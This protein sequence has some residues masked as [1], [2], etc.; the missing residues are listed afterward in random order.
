MP[1]AVFFDRDGVLNEAVIKNGMPFAPETVADLKI[2]PE[3]PSA[4]AALKRAGFFLVCVT[5]Q[6]DVARGWTK[7]ELVEDINMAVRKALSLDDLRACYHDDKDNCDCRKPKPGMLLDS[8]K[9]FD[10]D[11]DKSFM[12]GDRSKDIEAGRNAGVRTVFIERHYSEKLNVKPD[13]VT[14]SLMSAA[15]WILGHR[16][17]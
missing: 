7:K 10:L 17:D 14:P 9:Q 15:T 3:A 2:N 11:L 8:A 4:C 13:F 12:V 5:N 16:G 6:P 1:S